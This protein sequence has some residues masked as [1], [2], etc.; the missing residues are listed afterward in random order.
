MASAEVNRPSNM[1]PHASF[2][3]PHGEVARKRQLFLKV[4]EY[5]SGGREY[6]AG[7]RAPRPHSTTRGYSTNDAPP[8]PLTPEV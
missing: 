8:T 4:A 7:P 1:A 3:P 5:V 6:G 2:R